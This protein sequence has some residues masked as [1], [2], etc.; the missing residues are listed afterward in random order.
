MNK[1]KMLAAAIASLGIAS[2][3]GAGTVA[4]QEASGTSLAEKIATQFNL[5]KDDVQKVIDSDHA[6]RHAEMQ[7]RAE[8]RLQEAVDAG[9]ITAEQ[10]D[11][12]VAKMKELES[13]REARREEMKNKTE[14][15][16][17]ATM[18]AERDELKK[19]AEENNIPTQYLM[20]G[21]R[22]HGGPGMGSMRGDGPP[23]NAPA[24]N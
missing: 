4:A 2:V 20:F 6:E 1:K 5:N 18:K 8:E 23:P 13:S 7:K 9:K 10:K 19:W 11:K 12:I 17:R 16:R 22:G 24:E 21:G 15:E 3:V 14:E